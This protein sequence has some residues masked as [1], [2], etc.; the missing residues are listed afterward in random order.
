MKIFAHVVL[1]ALSV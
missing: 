1:V